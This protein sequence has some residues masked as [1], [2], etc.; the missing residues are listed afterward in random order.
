M[1]QFLMKQTLFHKIIFGFLGRVYS[2]LQLFSLRMLI[3]YQNLPNFVTLLWN[4]DNPDYQN[5]G[6][7]GSMNDGKL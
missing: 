4:F 2:Q 6:G 5:G 3:L 7:S 1:V